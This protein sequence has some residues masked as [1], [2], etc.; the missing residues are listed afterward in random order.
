VSCNLT[1]FYYCESDISL[2]DFLKRDFRL[3][4]GIAFEDV[5]R[6]D[7][8][9]HEAKLIEQNEDYLRVDL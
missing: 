2:E 7:A 1:R 5:E 4:N 3:R 9:E 8:D 6:Q